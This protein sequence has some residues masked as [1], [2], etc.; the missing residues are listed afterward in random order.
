MLIKHIPRRY[1]H[2]RK[3]YD[4]QG[5]FGQPP[6][7]RLVRPNQCPDRRPYHQ[8]QGFP[9]QKVVGLVIHID[10]GQRLGYQ[11]QEQTCGNCL[12]NREPGIEK[13]WYHN[14][15][16]T[17]ADQTDE[18]AGDEADT[19]EEGRCSNHLVGV[20]DLIVYW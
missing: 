8:Y 5:P 11:L 4:I 19:D 16:G 14:D 9:K 2:Q 3:Q 13:H 6:V 12:L 1:H 20:Y 10:R 15:A 18:I 7:R 17:D